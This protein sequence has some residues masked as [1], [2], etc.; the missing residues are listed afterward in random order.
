MKGFGGFT[1]AR[2]LQTN[3]HEISIIGELEAALGAAEISR[4]PGM[5][6]GGQGCDECGSK[7]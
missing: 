7:K 6:S 4:R 2:D 5:W 1:P 3:V